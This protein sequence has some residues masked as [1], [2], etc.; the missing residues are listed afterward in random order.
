MASRRVV[1]VALII[2]LLS[3]VSQLAIANSNGKFNSSNGCNCHGGSA[4]SPTPTHNFPTTYSPGQTYSLSIGMNGGVSGSKGGFNLQVSDGTLSTGM[5]IMNTQVNSAGNQATH[6]FP[7]YRSWGIEW[8]APSSGSGTVTFSLAV[9]AANG[10][11]NNGGDGWATVSVQSS[12]DSGSTNTPPEASSVS[13]M[14]SEPTKETGLSVSYNYY[15]A[16]GDFE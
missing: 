14:P 6:Q 7:D 13:Y 2:I 5:G 1:S 16:D 11:G 15:D 12:E 10:N 4:A 9:M 8:T 3:S